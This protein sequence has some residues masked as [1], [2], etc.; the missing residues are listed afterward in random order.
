MD[1]R[2]CEAPSSNWNLYEISRPN[3]VD[4][5]PLNLSTLVLGSWND[6]HAYCRSKD[7]YLAT[8][9][10]S[11]MEQLKYTLIL[12]YLQHG[13]NHSVAYIFVGLHHL[14]SAIFSKRYQSKQ[15]RRN[16]TRFNFN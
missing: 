6:A 7:L 1:H 2:Y 13:W 16:F 3:I 5:I 4:K 14:V 8:S 10:P 15:S 11:I 12:Q 9:T